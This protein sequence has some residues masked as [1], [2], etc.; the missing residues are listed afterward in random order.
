M[1]EEELIFKM[2]DEFKP[3]TEEEQESVLK[4]IIITYFE[5]LNNMET[6]KSKR[7]KELWRVQMMTYGTFI[8]L[9]TE[10]K[11]LKKVGIDRKHF[12]IKS[13]KGLWEDKYGKQTDA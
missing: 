1:N 4:G 6:S 11:N 5:C 7:K 2:L 13:L 10:N 9:L 12:L 3:L 8:T